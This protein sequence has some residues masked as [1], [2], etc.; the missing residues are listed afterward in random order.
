MKLV[1]KTHLFLAR[2]IWKHLYTIILFLFQ[3]DL[4]KGVAGS[5]LPNELYKKAEEHAP[6]SAMQV[7]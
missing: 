1:S 6:L 4:N 7:R 2:E 3:V 5:D